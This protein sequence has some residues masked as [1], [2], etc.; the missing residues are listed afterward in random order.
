MPAILAGA[1]AQ[2]SLWRG[3][4]AGEKPYIH[5][6]MDLSEDRVQTAKVDF[7]GTNYGDGNADNLLYYANCQYSLT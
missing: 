3:V 4:S 1:K 2:G 5:P 6:F 7:V